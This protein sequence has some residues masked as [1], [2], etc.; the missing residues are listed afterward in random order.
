MGKSDKTRRRKVTISS[1]EQDFL[2]GC[3]LKTRS[4]IARI[5]LVVLLFA[6]MVVSCGVGGD[7]EPNVSIPMPYISIT[8]DEPTSDPFYEEFTSDVTLSGKYDTP[9]TYKP[10]ISWVNHT[11]GKYGVCDLSYYTPTWSSTVPVAVGD[12]LIEVTV[13]DSHGQTDSASIT[14]THPNYHEPYIVDFTGYGTS[15]HDATFQTDI[16]TGGYSNNLNIYYG[17]NPSLLQS[18]I[19]FDVSDSPHLQSFAATVSGLTKGLTH[20]YQITLSGGAAG[21]YSSSTKNFD[22][23]VTPTIT[24]LTCSVNSFTLTINP[25]G[26]VT[27]VYGYPC[28]A[29]VMNICDELDVSWGL[30]GSESPLTLS[31]GNIDLSRYDFLLIEAINLGGTRYQRCYLN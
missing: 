9:T 7:L 15:A 4:R 8:I 11:T 29:E 30:H 5:L 25:N 18:V 16:E 27:N 21:S 22:M 31:W 23:I 6:P 14:I 3:P 17:T 24:G 1:C 2:T 12:N 20:Y 26:Y 13:M 10:D 28:L 19:T